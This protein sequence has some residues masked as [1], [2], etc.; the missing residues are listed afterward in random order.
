MISALTGYIRVALLQAALFSLST[1]ERNLVCNQNG[2]KCPV[3]GSMDKI[4][5]SMDLTM[6]GQRGSSEA[7][8]EM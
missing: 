8:S 5:L 4:V 7:I 2:K 6:G 1:F 3:H